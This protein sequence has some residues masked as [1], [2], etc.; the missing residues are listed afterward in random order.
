MTSMTERRRLSV[1][2][3][4]CP[5]CQ[6]TNLLSG[7]RVANETQLLRQGPCREQVPIWEG[8]M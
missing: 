5:V 6:E 7:L 2:F 8:I 4:L 3:V 1:A